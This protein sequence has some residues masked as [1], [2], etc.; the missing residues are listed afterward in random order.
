MNVKEKLEVFKKN[1]LAE[2][3]EMN[4]RLLED[5]RRRY[6]EAVEAIGAA[7]ARKAD[8]RIKAEL[9]REESR[10]NKEV[11]DAERDARRVVVECRGGLAAA[12][13]AAVS[14]LVGE[15]MGTEAYVESAIKRSPKLRANTASRRNSR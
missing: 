13:A 3:D 7:A 8:G 5:V 15:Y 2:A 9:A 14:G 6:G 4:G 10:M 1:A 12:F 11:T